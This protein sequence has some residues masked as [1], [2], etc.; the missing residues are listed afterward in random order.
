MKKYDVAAIGELLIDFTCESADASGYPLLSAHPGGAPANYLSTL[1]KFGM[2]T[3][4]IGKVGDDTFGRLLRNTLSSLSVDV[5]GIAVDKTVFTTL[6]FVTLDASG[7]REFAFSRKPGA[8]TQ[9]RFEEMNL[10]QIDASSVLHFGTLSLTDEPA[11]SSTYRAVEYARSKEKLISFDPNLR[12]MLWDSLA[13]AKTQMEWGLQHADVVKISAE[14]C[15]F[16]WQ[17]CPEEAAE[18]LIHE[19]GTALALVTK[20][21]EGS[22]L[23]NGK[24]TVSVPALNVRAVDTTGAGDI[25]GGSAMYQ[26]LR[27]QKRICDLSADDLFSIGHFASVTAGLS[28]EKKGGISSIPCLPEVQERL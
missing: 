4:F 22:V 3:A 27:L 1:A 28:T 7:N 16:L 20:G 15:E 12:E 14:E 17:L 21:A 26:F 2:E 11:R 10:R 19:Y 23:S 8:D 24:Y 5:S 9:I 18:K 25:F 6:A 13:D